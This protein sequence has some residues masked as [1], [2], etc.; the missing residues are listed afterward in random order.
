MATHLIP[1]P[2]REVEPAASPAPGGKALA[3]LREFLDKEGMASREG[4]TDFADFE[5]KLHERLMEVE[6][7]VVGEVMAKADVDAEAVVIGGR[8]HRKVLRGPETYLTAAGPVRVE[9]TLYKDRTL[10]AQ[11]AVSVMEL[12]LGVVG[13]MWT[14]LAAEQGSWVVAQ[15]TPGKAEELFERLGNMQPSKSS[16]DRLPKLISERWEAGR[17]TFESVLR[18]GEGIPEGTKSVA[19]SLDGVL[20]PME[21]TK[22]PE[23]RRETASRGRLTRGPAGYREVGCGTLSFCDGEGKLLKAVRLARA[24]EE[25]KATLKGMLQAELSAALAKRPDLRVVKIADGAKDNWTFLSQQLPPGPDVLDFYHAAEHLNAALAAAYGDGTV[26]QRARFASLRE[27]LLDDPDGAG[28]VIA[29]LKYL[30]EKHPRKKKLATELAYFRRHRHHMQ[31]RTW[32]DEGLPVGSGVVEAACKTL[33]AQRLKLSGMQWGD[34]GAQA[35]L[36][37]RGWDQ[38]DRFDRAWALVAA[39]FHAD[40]TTVQ[41]APRS[42]A[43]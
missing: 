28:K 37:L 38:S 2:R 6:R 23:K 30:H 35:I 15:L 22:G 14:P 12:R 26:E 3:K 40:V 10:P 24:P 20:A 7:E 17:E 5:R 13:G 34:R 25:H 36:T 42:E 19:V 21:G 33:V 9:R 31:Y 29:A 43:A 16:L 27:V 18:E 8:V 41:V 1:F 32:Q 4:P 39:T 11:R